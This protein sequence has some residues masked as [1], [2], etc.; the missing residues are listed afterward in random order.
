MTQE[1]RIEILE[2][3]L[4]A[5]KAASAHLFIALESVARIAFEIPRSV[6]ETARG[7]RPTEDTVRTMRAATSELDEALKNAYQCIWNEDGTPK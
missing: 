7:A 1:E 4:S 6:S 3:E 5:V 2:Q